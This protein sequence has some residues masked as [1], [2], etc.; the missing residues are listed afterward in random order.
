[1]IRARHA[2]SLIGSTPEIKAIYEELLQVSQ[3]RA[4]VILRGESG[5]GKE[6]IARLIHE[7]SPRAKE[8]FI[9]VNCAALPETLLE[10]ELFGHEQGAFT[11]AIKT[12]KGRFEL[13]DGGTLFLDEI[14]DLPFS[15]QVKLLHVLQEG[16]FERVGGVET[17]TVDVR[18][19]SATHRNLEKAIQQGTFREDLYYRLNVIP[20]VLPPLRE[21][22]GDIPLLVQHFLK[23]FNEEN[24]K[25]VTL[26]MEINTLFIKYNWPG[27]IRELENCIERLVVLAQD[28]AI[29]IKTIPPAIRTYFSDIQKVI[30]SFQIGTSLVE[31]TQR[32]E[33]EAVKNALEKSGGVQ[34][35]AARLLGMTA[36]QI[37]Y[38]IKKYKMGIE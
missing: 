23:K 18:I 16:T 27:N 31:T 20:I 4:T 37:A 24:K 3:S 35:K 11:G 19:V 5:T 14:G 29:T 10:S 28:H 15:V 33:Q 2:N 36:R 30:P 21:R 9:K 38:K 22:Q 12:K 25:N 7:N 6:L 32:I 1:M 8:P 17:R 13:A 26:S 34:A